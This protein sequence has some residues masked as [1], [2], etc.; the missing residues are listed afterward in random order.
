MEFLSENRSLISLPKGKG[1]AFNLTPPEMDQDANL[2]A[3]RFFGESTVDGILS[4]LKR[5][6]MS[7]RDLMDDFLEYD[8]KHPPPCRDDPVYKL[9]FQSVLDEWG[10]GPKLIPLTLGAAAKHPD[11][12]RGKSPGLPWKNLGFK[13][14]ADVLENA[15]AMNSIGASWQRIGAGV[16]TALPDC[17][18]FARAQICPV[19]KN[20]IRATW[21]YPMDV[22]IEEARFFFPLLG[23]IKS[24]ELDVPIGYQVEMSTGGMTFINEMVKAHPGA[25]IKIA[26]WSKFDKRVPPWLIRDAF[27]I[28]YTKFEWDKVIDS[29]GKIWHVRP[30]RSQRRW[31]RI[32]RY[33]IDTP[34]RTCKGERFMKKG[35]VPSGSCFTNIVDTIINQLMQRYVT[36]HTTGQFPLAEI[37]LGDDSV[38]VELGHVNLEDQ[39]A[40]ALKV[41]G[42]VLN[43]AKSYVTTNPRNAHFLGYFNADGFPLKAQDFSIASF[44]LPEHTVKEP[45]ITAAR[46]VGQLYCS[47]DPRWA[48][49]WLDIV[50]THCSQYGFKDEDVSAEMR[51][52]P[53]RYKFLA[54][55]GV[56]PRVVVVPK[57]DSGYSL[58]WSVLPPTTSRKKYV[59]RRFDID[60]IWS[61]CLEFWWP[62]TEEEED[63]PFDSAEYGEI[64][65]DAHDEELAH[66]D[67]TENY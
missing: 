50:H 59:K 60:A 41:F 29:E 30:E 36:Y 11:V 13:T 40:L 61:R 52:K 7:Y 63:L 47:F 4:T 44:I 19:E 10:A 38:T 67:Q 37:Y 31:N 1:F 23:Q 65:P 22:Y 49:T 32:V 57:V 53:F 28:L 9:A 2:L 33:F 18:L 34:V 56:D 35:G 46:A 26:D 3:R 25:K 66:L 27:Y 58:V 51:E 6:T 42:A 24:G 64:E 15:E 45:I 5:A 43:I 55:I 48:S 54:Q 20:K 16:P 12:P 21:G 62:E 39:A 8:V 17:A 14:K